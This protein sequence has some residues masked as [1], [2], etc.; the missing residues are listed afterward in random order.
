MSING[1]LL[2]AAIGFVAALMLIANA[3]HGTLDEC[4]AA[5]PGYDCNFGWVVGEAFK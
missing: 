5:H 1:V 2:G 4:R 3:F